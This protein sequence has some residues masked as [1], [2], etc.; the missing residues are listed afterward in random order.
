MS[1]MNLSV[2]L[3]AI[4]GGIVNELAAYLL[5]HNNFAITGLNWSRVLGVMVIGAII[6]VASWW[7]GQRDGSQGSQVFPKK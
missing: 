4:I 3:V 1:H 7:K 2:L 5:D 6:G